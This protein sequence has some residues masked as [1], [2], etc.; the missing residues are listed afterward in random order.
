MLKLQNNGSDAQT[1]TTDGSFQ[2]SPALAGST[3]SVTVSQHPAARQ[4]A[5]ANATGNLTGTI[6][7]VTVSCNAGQV[8]TLYS[9]TGTGSDGKY[10]S[11]GLIQDNLGNLFGTTTAGGAAGMGTVFMLSRNAD[12]TYAPA[13]TLYS[14]TGTGSDGSN[15]NAGLMIDSAGNVLGTTNGGGSANVGTVFELTR[16]ANGTYAPAVTLHSFTG[17]GTDGAY[18]DGG[19]IADSAGNLFGTTNQGGTASFGTVFELTRNSDG[20]Y[21]PPATLY[22]FSG[23]GS[24]GKLPE[25]G[26]IADTG[27]NLFGTTSAGGT[28]NNG[29]VFELK[30]NSNGTYA[31]AITLHSFAG[32]GSDGAT[33]NS[34]LIA[35]SAG[36]LF[37]TTSAGGTA[38]FGTVF[39]IARNADGTYAS[40]STLHSFAGVSADGAYP[41]AGLILDGAGNLFGTTSAGGTVNMGAVFELKRNG[42]G[43]YASA[44][45]LLHS[46]TGTGADGQ[47]PVASLILDSSGNLFGTTNSGGSASVGTVFELN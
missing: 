3:Y 47:N 28:A 31:S 13:V 19:L 30:R 8:S 7:N 6:N 44:I 20:T 17:S 5:I 22:S 24:D 32:T 34:A 26:L 18:P 29:T 4:C 39:E 35:D 43:I 40:A 42:D 41:D 37:G 10:P 36:N 1:L 38:S 14:F 45:T 46:F 2:F 21:A 12:G 33:P 27:G 23:T 11:A 25:A 16:N 9:F 15:P